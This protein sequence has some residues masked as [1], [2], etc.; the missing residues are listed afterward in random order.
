M[1]YRRATLRPG[2]RRPIAAVE[3]RADPGLGLGGVVV[4]ADEPLGAEGPPERV[5]GERE[6]ERLAGDLARV[7]GHR[8]TLAVERGGDVDRAW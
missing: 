1:R 4:E 5:V 3:L 2:R 8:G 7:R 6:E